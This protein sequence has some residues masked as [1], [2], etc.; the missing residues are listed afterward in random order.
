MVYKVKYASSAC[1]CCVCVC[2][3]SAC[4]CCVCMCVC[5]GGAPGETLM[6]RGTSGEQV[7]VRVLRISCSKHKEV[8]TISVHR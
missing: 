8:L 4:V 7:G 5:V 2:A 6:R 1:V 3:V